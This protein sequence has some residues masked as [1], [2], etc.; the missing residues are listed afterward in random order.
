MTNITRVNY[1]SKLIE[2]YWSISLAEIIFYNQL[3]PSHSL[4][5]CIE[6]HFTILTVINIITRFT[7]HPGGMF[8][9]VTSVSKQPAT[10]YTLI[11][12][13]LVVDSPDMGFH[14][15]LRSKHLGA[16]RTLVVY[17]GSVVKIHWKDRIV[18]DRSQFKYYEVCNILFI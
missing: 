3:K 12:F 16:S 6:I 8:P 10:C 2:N 17:R 4:T 7:N 13:Q 15:G 9:E 1:Q 5:Y 14:V 18:G 11:R